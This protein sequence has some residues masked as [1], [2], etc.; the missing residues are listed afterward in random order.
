M[1]T[2]TRLDLKFFRVVSKYRLPRKLHFTIFPRKVSTV[3]FSE[4]GSVAD[5]GEG[6]GG[7]GPPLFLDQTEA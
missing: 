1:T 2:S 3:T 4:G 6:P 7:P 5:P